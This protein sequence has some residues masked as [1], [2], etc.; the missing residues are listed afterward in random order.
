MPSLGS[1][2]KSANLI[3]RLAIPLF[4]AKHMLFFKLDLYQFSVDTNL[5][6]S[7]TFLT[8]LSFSGDL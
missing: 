2:Q 7:I 8:P 1:F 3:A 5:A 4:S 6:H